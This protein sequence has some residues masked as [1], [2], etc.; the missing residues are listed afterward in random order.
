MNSVESLLAENNLQFTPAGQ[1]YLIKCLNPEHD[2]NNPSLRI[3]R[4]SGV[5]HCFACGFSLNIFNYY[6]KTPNVLNI[7]LEEIK[8]KISKILY[9]M[10]G[11]QLPSQV[12][13]IKTGLRG[14]SAETIK[15]FGFFTTTEKMP[16]GTDLSEYILVPLYD[17]GKLM[18]LIG[19][20]KVP[21]GK[22]KY[23]FWPRK[24]IIPIFP[25]L[26]VENNSIVLVEGMFDALFLYDNGI[27]NVFCCFGTD[28]FMSRFREYEATFKI[29][30]I[31]KFY[32]M[33][34]GD[35]AGNSAAAKIQSF[36]EKHG[37]LAEIIELGE[38][39][40]PTDLDLDQLQETKK[41]INGK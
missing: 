36:L 18:A 37:Y 12:E 41:Y 20:H 17:S 7:K 1:D 15:E 8:Q 9:E 3:D 6:N 5:G 30:N 28:T 27:K 24:A 4:I 33:F 14:I 40:D 21:D 25:K 23:K 34:D 29:S 16:D 26:S 35:K 10:H 11:I 39:L 22:P 19:R 13:L 31:S 32:I 38:G 2:D